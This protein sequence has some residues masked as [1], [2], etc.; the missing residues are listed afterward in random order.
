[1][2]ILNMCVSASTIENGALILY[3]KTN[4]LEN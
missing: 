2:W 4:N 3:L 1:M